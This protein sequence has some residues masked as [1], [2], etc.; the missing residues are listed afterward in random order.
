LQRIGDE[1]HVECTVVIA[2]V[3]VVFV[4]GAAVVIAFVNR[5]HAAP[6]SFAINQREAFAEFVPD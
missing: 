2:V 5:S 3:V 1:E 4:T 6:G